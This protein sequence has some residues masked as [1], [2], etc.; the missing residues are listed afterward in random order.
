MG[1]TSAP[2]I[3]QRAPAD[4]RAIC[5]AMH[6]HMR[7]NPVLWG[8]TFFPELD[9]LTGDAGAKSLIAAHEDVVCE[10]EADSAV[11]RDIDT[12]EALAELRA[13]TVAE[14]AP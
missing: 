5:V 14:P 7:G 8:K 3:G 2:S 4:G 13:S 9:E 10:I 12:P 1:V 6:Q 11:L